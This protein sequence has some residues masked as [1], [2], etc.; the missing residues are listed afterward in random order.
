MIELILVGIFA[1]SF[2]LNLFNVSGAVIVMLLTGSILAMAYFYLSVVMFNKIPYRQ[3]LKRD[4]YK[5][6]SKLRLLGSAAVGIALSVLVIGVLFVIMYWPG[7]SSMLL[8]GIVASVIL[9]GVALYKYFT[10]RDFFY[11]ALIRRL[12]VW[13][14]AGILLYTLPANVLIGIKY[15]NNPA[16]RD[17]VINAME[18]PDDE[19]IHQKYIE[20]A[21]KLDAEK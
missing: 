15:R 10:K 3:V 6:I 1:V 20:E 14:A 18:N 8:L 16:Y 7:G 21:K 17:A 2:I 12:T 11:P 4:A 13:I 9:M 5:G 19:E